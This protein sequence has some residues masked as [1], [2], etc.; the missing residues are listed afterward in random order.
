[1]IIAIA[2]VFSG[3]LP[4][5]EAVCTCAEIHFLDVTENQGELSRPWR[6][7]TSLRGYFVD[8]DEEEDNNRSPSDASDDEGIDDGSSLFV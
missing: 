4:E 5:L 3:I 8:E 7:G 1:M 6:N 2:K